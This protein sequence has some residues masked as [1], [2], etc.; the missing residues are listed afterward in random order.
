MSRIGLGTWAMGGQRWRYSWGRQDDAQ[1]LRTIDAALDLGIDWIDTAPV[2]G[3]G[4]AEE[5]V[6]RALHG[7]RSQVAIATKC[8]FLWKGGSRRPYPRLTAASVFEEVE[9]SLRRLSTDYIDLYQIHWPGPD[10]DLEGGWESIGRLV[11]QGKVRCGGVCNLS[12]EE[13]A[14]LA[15]VGRS[16]ASLQLPCNLI[17]QPPPQLI[18]QANSH[19]VC[20][21]GYSP[22]ASGRLCTGFG[23][24]RVA[25]L[26][27]DDWR[28]HHPDF[29]SAAIERQAPLRRALRRLAEAAGHTLEE[30]ALAWALSAVDVGGAVVL[31]AR[32]PEQLARSAGG[33]SVAAPVLAEID[34]SLVG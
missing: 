29:S 15:S 1:S 28:A 21:L 18:D 4:H 6:G 3:V 24:D 31:G 14:R 22:L 34:A 19:G 17:D 20:L 32:S 27:G 23:H 9:A 26:P 8:G 5:L 12:V 2:Y 13:L 7:R 25:R 10:C 30:L 16:P 11:E 33:R